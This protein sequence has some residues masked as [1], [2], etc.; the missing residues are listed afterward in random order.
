[1]FK[2]DDATAAAGQYTEGTPGVTAPTRV[3][4]DH[5][6]AIQN[7][8]SNVVEGFGLTLAKATSTQMYDAL[9]QVMARQAVKGAL[10][11]L[12]LV[13]DTGTVDWKAIVQDSAGASRNILVAGEGGLLYISNS[14]GDFVVEPAAGG[15]TDVFYGATYSSANSLFYVC[16]ELGEIQSLTGNATPGSATVTQRNTGGIDTLNSIAAGAGTVVAVGNAETILSG[17]TTF[18]TRTS[19]LAGTP[20][21][22]SVAF[23]AAIFV[24][25]TDTG[26]IIS[27]TDGTTWTQRQ[28][29][30]GAA[31]TCTVEYES[32]IGFIV[33]Y[34][35]A[36]YI[37]TDGITWTAMT[38]S[39]IQLDAASYH[40]FAPYLWCE[41]RTVAGFGT[42]IIMRKVSGTTATLHATQ[43]YV[44][45][46]NA[47]TVVK[48]INSQIW[49]LTSDQIWAG[50]VL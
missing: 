39:G 26:A 34:G 13:D 8:I 44:M 46:G 28:A 45:G 36:A 42:Q 29:A 47:A 37:S 20:N 7:E 17:L 49:A 3:R 41:V 48:V 12:H 4:A 6:N 10:A 14:R 50:G 21:F 5:L 2:A 18:T 38:I 27:S 24:A 32:T 19:P 9:V 30:V 40:F 25:A 1:M 16:G 11:G 31:A 43:S 33:K 15:F 35:N 22:L 23:G